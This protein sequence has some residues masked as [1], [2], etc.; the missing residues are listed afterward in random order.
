M[1]LV[2]MAVVSVPMAQAQLRMG[3]KLGANVSN[4]HGEF[5][6]ITLDGEHLT[7]FT[8][9]I[10]VEWIVAFGL[11]IDAGVNY[12]AKGSEYTLGSEELAMKNL[13]HYIEVP[14]NLKYK[15]QIPVVEDL[16]IPLIYTGPSFA[17]KV[18]E[19]ITLNGN[20]YEGGKLVSINNNAV[21]IAWNIGAGVELFRHLNVTA[22]YGWGINDVT[23]MQ[24]ENIDM[25]REKKITSG[26]W[27]ITATWMF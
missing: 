18:G 25:M 11:G 19:A 9:G 17:F 4:F 13:I 20:F 16:I 1:L 5:D 12:T 2:M 14:V 27:T 10:T 6:D 21:D 22:Q 3:L 26:V 24:M 15:L 8:G 7:N 23:N